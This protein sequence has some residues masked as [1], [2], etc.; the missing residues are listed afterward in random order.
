MQES[1][2]RIT[3]TGR[4]TAINKEDV[5]REAKSRKSRMKSRVSGMRSACMMGCALVAMLAWSGVCSAA[6]ARGIALLDLSARTK[7]TVETFSLDQGLR[8]AGVPY[9]TTQDLNAAVTNAMVVVSSA[10]LP[11]TFTAAEKKVLTTYVTNG[12]VL[13]A[14]EVS[15]PALFS[16]FG[17]ATAATTDTQHTLTWNVAGNDPSLRWFD[18]PDEIT[19]RLAN[20]VLYPTLFNVTGYGLMKTAVPL[21]FFESGS[22]AVTKNFYNKKGYAY[23]LGFSF[24]NLI[25]RNQLNRDCDAQI[26]YSNTFEPTTDTVILFLRAI[27]ESHVSLAAWKHTSP[28]ASRAT[29]IMTHDVDCQSSMDSMILFADLEYQRGIT[30]SYNITTHYIK[31]YFDHDYYTPNIQKI[32]DVVA[33]N[34]KIGSHSM[35]HFPDYDNEIIFPEGVAGNTRATYTPRYTWDKLT[36]TGITTGGTVYGELEVSKHLLETDIGVPIRAYRSGYLIWNDKQINVM[37]ALGYKYDSSQSANN[38]LTNFPF[39]CTYDRAYTGKLTGIYE[40]G[41]TISD[42]GIAEDNYPE[43]VANWID[44]TTRNAAN[45]APTLLLLHPNRAFKVAAEEMLLNQLP[46]DILVTDMETYGDFWRERDAFTFTT[47]LNKTELVIT[48]PDA[49]LPVSQNQSIMISEGSTIRTL[50]VKTASGIKVNYQRAAAQD[51]DIILY[52]FSAV[53]PPQS[54]R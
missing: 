43:L 29:F 5:M 15:D 52:A 10:I 4:E 46:A 44:V 40:I 30:A 47:T 3:D 24:K 6:L 2:F 45:S 42:K 25:L 9:S 28:G 26:E 51:Q 16:L 8:T 38:M 31:D 39:L 19:I 37:D 22:V 23:A 20:P 36:G 49:V 50:T 7:A 54:R 11:A 13:V 17:I 1:E 35:G 48:I 21:A 18:D 32:R 14:P 12:G 33:R 41:L 27:F 53:K 34:H